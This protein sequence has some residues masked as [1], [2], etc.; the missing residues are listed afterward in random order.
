MQTTLHTSHV[1][2]CCLIVVFAHAGHP[3]MLVPTYKKLKWTNNMPT[4][5]GFKLNLG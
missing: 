2:I 3:K 1:L 5:S 4:N